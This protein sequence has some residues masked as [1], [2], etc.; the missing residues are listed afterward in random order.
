[1]ADGDKNTEQDQLD[2][3]NAI[4]NPPDRPS[5][6]ANFVFLRDKLG[7]RNEKVRKYLAEETELGKNKAKKRLQ[8]FDRESGYYLLFEN[9][10][11][12]FDY[13][14][15]VLEMQEKLGD[16]PIMEHK[17][18][19]PTDLTTYKNELAREVL[20][21]WVADRRPSDELSIDRA[22]DFVNQHLF[23]DYQYNFETEKAIRLDKRKQNRLKAEIPY[24]DASAMN[25][26]DQVSNELMHSP[27]YMT[28]NEK[29]WLAVD[30]AIDAGLFPSALEDVLETPIGTVTETTADGR[31]VQKRVMSISELDAVAVLDAMGVSLEPDPVSQ[32]FG[33][34]ET[35]VD[36]LNQAVVAQ[37]TASRRSGDT[38]GYWGDIATKTDDERELGPEDFFPR[39]GS[40][41]LAD[42]EL[43]MEFTGKNWNFSESPED[44]L[45]RLFREKSVDYGD[46]G[47]LSL[48]P[49]TKTWPKDLSSNYTDKMLSRQAG[50]LMRETI[51]G[52]GYDEGI[53]NTDEGKAYIE[54]WKA[55]DDNPTIEDAFAL[56]K[57]FSEQVGTN[58]ENFQGALKGNLQTVTDS[59]WSKD[60]KDIK[61][62]EK[63]AG[64]YLSRLEGVRDDATTEDV[65]ELAGDLLDGKY[66]SLEDMLD[67]PELEAKV[68][69]RYNK[70][71]ED[72]PFD[73]D[74]RATIGGRQS[75]LNTLLQRELTEQDWNAYLAASPEDKLALQA[76]LTSF[77][78]EAQALANGGFRAALNKA[79]SSGYEQIAETESAQLTSGLEGGLF[80]EFQKRGLITADS[81]QA[82]IDHLTKT[83]FP[84]LSQRAM[85]AGGIE[86]EED[87]ARIIDEATSGRRDEQGQL[88]PGALA[89]YDLYESDFKRQ[90]GVDEFGRIDVDQ[91]PLI[92]GL[93][94]SRYKKEE[95]PAFNLAAITP[96]L[97]NIAMEDPSLAGFIQQQMGL[98]GFAEEWEREGA[99]Q[100]DEAAFKSAI[101]G[102]VGQ[103]AFDL[104]K[105]KLDSFEKQYEEA[106]ARDLTPE[107]R[108]QA[109]K[110]IAR[111]RRDF[112][113]EVAA[114]PMDPEERERFE[115]VMEEDYQKAVARDEALRA[116]GEEG[117]TEQELQK[118]EFAQTFQQQYQ[119]IKDAIAGEKAK[120]AA[121]QADLEA[122]K[123]ETVGTGLEPGEDPT[124]TQQVAKYSD[125]QLAS[126]QA[127]IDAMDVG[128]A[129]MQKGV[130]P[131]PTGIDKYGKKVEMPGLKLDLKG[132]TGIEFRDE[133]RERLTSAGKTSQEFFASK[134]PGFEERYKE[135][136]FFKL[137]QERKEREQ[138][139]KRRPLLRTGGRGRTVVTRGRA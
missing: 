97:Q 119:P 89:A 101:F 133:E 108:E 88:V 4:L 16:D 64:E 56:Y 135:S 92:P 33:M 138:T 90:F 110:R 42:Q 27:E 53:L 96:S 126:M 5:R 47:N 74:E 75:I 79:I 61:Q 122:A 136:P 134:L 78:S 114:S 117:L 37:T 15:D 7:V 113:R 116:A 21:H 77:D 132:L 71:K 6:I 17:P 99:E 98:P 139:A 76:Q 93:E 9:Q 68:R 87:I 50:D 11:K 106:L 70:R 39:F 45:E 111:A 41:E 66:T 46:E 123:K 44:N 35:F 29:F 72:R 84:K 137:E 130:G 65:R 3:W 20:N 32:L 43:F 1:M 104:Q 80:E 26:M 63:V 102:D 131:A 2:I 23:Y 85:L 121:L 13:D 28:K 82:Y 69:D 115:A 103:E 54:K 128:I 30:E 105:T 34:T 10:F 48:H 57:I 124:I 51:G 14:T 49:N 40:N 38:K 95:A 60:M 83:V 59:Q 24:K 67:D 52:E 25:I 86:K 129:G 55:S 19:T 58:F 112:A 73:P 31:E 36:E 18:K 94:I 8:E 118:G 100:F 120:Q 22:M 91:P 107:E 125:E 62:R 12:E 109:E 81:S 127:A